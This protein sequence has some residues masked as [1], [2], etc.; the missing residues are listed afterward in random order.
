[1]TPITPLV[2][3]PIVVPSGWTFPGALV[4]ASGTDA[5]PPMTLIVPFEQ[6]VVVPSQT[7]VPR[8]VFVAGGTGGGLANRR[9][10]MQIS[11]IV[12]MY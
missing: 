8:T 10:G 4:V 6:V 9:E 3:T 7:T 11:A 12:A 5:P 2:L 1:M